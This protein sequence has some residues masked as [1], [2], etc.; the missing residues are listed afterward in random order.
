MKSTVDL[1]KSVL[2]IEADSLKKA[3][4][5]ITQD[6]VDAGGTDGDVNQ[7]G[8]EKSGRQQAGAGDVVI[9]QLPEPHGRTRCGQDPARQQDR[10]REY[11]FGNVHGV[12][13]P[14]SLRI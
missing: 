7:R 8:H 12:N 10:A 2:D 3:A 14:A 9:V 4:E 13:S 6:Q 11:A 5:R 1:F